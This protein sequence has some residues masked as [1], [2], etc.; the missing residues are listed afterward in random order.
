MRN[1]ATKSDGTTNLGAT[2]FNADQDEF[3]NA[4]TTADDTLDPAGGPDTDLFMLSKA[5][6]GYAGA[7]WAYQD[8]GAADAYVLSIASN[9]KPPTK[10]FDNMMV[11]FKPGNT[12][13]GA[14]TV[15]VAG[16]GVKNIKIEGTDPVA[17]EIATAKIIIM[18]YNDS[19][20]YFEIATGAGT[21]TKGQHNHED[22]ANGGNLGQVQAT[23]ITFTGLPAIPPNANTQTKKNIIG[24]W[25]DFKGTG[26][27]SI[28]DSFNVSSIIDN[29]GNGNYTIVI[30]TDFANALWV[31]FGMVKLNS[32]S[33]GA[34]GNSIEVTNNAGGKVSTSMGVLTSIENGTLADM[35]G[36]YVGGVG[37]Q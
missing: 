5:I 34:Y 20:G 35:E 22:T 14:S 27:I 16:L 29:G 6:A 12:N 8:S 15:N 3:E 9:L 33:T 24:F 31:P 26:T 32:T 13:T 30:D 4:I 37:P 11:A 21:F 2:D 25:I 23:D 18:Q 1:I 36:V 19:A 10:Y 7:S 28:N 17:G